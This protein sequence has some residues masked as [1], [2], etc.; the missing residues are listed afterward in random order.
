M[1]K[2]KLA[3][4]TILTV[5]KIEMVDG[6]LNITTNDNTTEELAVIFEDKTKTSLITLL[7]DSEKETGYKKGFTSF[8]GI[9]YN[10]D[11]TKTVELFQPKDVTEA[12]VSNAEGTANKAIADIETVNDKTIGLEEQ[13]KLI[14]E[15][16]DALLTSVIPSLML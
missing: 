3:D 12:R 7:T 4:N 8:A 10:T 13:T 11:R 6:V 16:M 1:A 15:T 14:T 2:I 5:S 9:K